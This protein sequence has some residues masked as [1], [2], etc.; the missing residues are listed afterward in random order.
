MVRFRSQHRPPARNYF[1]GRERWRLFA[2]VMSLGLVV[3]F[4]NR[5][6]Q[7]ETAERLNLLFAGGAGQAGAEQPHD[8]PPEFRALPIVHQDTPP[9]GDYPGVQRDLLASI[10]DNTYF[11]TDEAPAWFH[12]LLILQHSSERELE[13]ASTADVG[14]IQL[15]QQPN[16]YR[17]RLVT[18]RGTVRQVAKEKPAD[19]ELGIASY[20]RLVIQPTGGGLWPIF[21]YVL[22]LPP[23][24]PQ[25]GD[26]SADVSVTGFF[27]KD[28]SYAWQGGL[29][30]A[31]V[32]L[33]KTITWP[34]DGAA[35]AEPP[36]SKTRVPVA[37][38]QWSV[39]SEAAP[40]PEFNEA[41][42]RELLALAGWGAEKW[43]GFHDGG[44]LTD[45]QKLQLLPL[46]RRLDTFDSFTLAQWAHSGP[47]WQSIVSQP[48]EHRGE[49]VSLSGRVQ[50]VQLHTLSAVD[51]A[52]L[53]MFKYYECELQLDGGGTATVLATQ[54]P[55]AWLSMP[56]LD[57]PASASALFIRMLPEADARAD[58]LFLSPRLAWHPTTANPPAVSFSESVLGTLGMD[59]GALDDVRNRDRILPTERAAFYEM[60]DAMGHIG[61]NQLVRFAQN[62]LPTVKAKWAAET[63]PLAADGAVTS[64]A[65]QS[66]SPQADQQRRLLAEEVLRRMS[67][68]QYSV[69]P[70]FNDADHQIGELVVLDGAVRRAVRVDVGTTPDGQP[71]D[72]WQRFGID[73]YYE[74][75]LFTDDSQNYPVVVCVRELPAGFPTGD[76]IHEPVRV[77]GFF[78]KTW[79]YHTRKVTNGSQSSFPV[80][81]EQRQF[82]P[83]LI[84]PA[85]LWLDQLPAVGSPYLGLLGSGLFVLAMA[86]MWAVA[87]WYAREDRRF[88]DRVLA[89]NYSLPEGR[90]LDDLQ[91]PTDEG[92]QNVVAR[93]GQDTS[94]DV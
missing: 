75:E 33:A 55:Q 94:G 45:D 1:S 8:S 62:N 17:G 68:G 42:L 4:M 43:A 82:A 49:L 41:S 28:L 46:L 61:A 44:P 58:A 71:S 57:E 5:L 64:T 73:H 89:R 65:A 9:R 69:A 67:A 91:A 72:V 53:E 59:V 81:E 85:P 30:I 80:G 70:L 3:I 34:A 10:R 87:W 92:P 31:P 24:F 14:Y 83:L 52:R 90:S 77:P 13:S 88:R 38:D 40:T 37:T 29:G 20:D 36:S 23:G 78:F 6:R 51:A 2:L 18:V 15:A 21:V 7:P 35:P 16:V 48:S 25:G 66:S 22:E 19:N 63:E 93:E 86:G 84:G 60:L 74:L 56:A 12:L 79:L 76:D 26:V 54:V 47:T 27:F 50:R 32:L 39:E 11:R